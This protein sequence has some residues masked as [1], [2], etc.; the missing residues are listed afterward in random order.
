MINS[1]IFIINQGKGWIKKGDAPAEAIDSSFT[2]KP[3]HPFANFCNMAPLAEGGKRLTKLGEE[4]IGGRKA[5]GI[6]VHP[7]GLPECDFFFGKQD[8]LMRKAK[9]VLPG[10]G[11]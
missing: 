8:G 4:T 7:D 9:Q 6:R 11:R 5:I 3:E 1:V 2:K 10:S